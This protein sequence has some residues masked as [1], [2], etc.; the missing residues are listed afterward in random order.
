ML[1]VFAKVKFL[2]HFISG[3]YPELSRVP[4]T[5]PSFLFMLGLIRHEI[6]LMQSTL[7]TRPHRIVMFVNP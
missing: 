3:Y 1:S 7:A 2:R 5:I 4:M 6:A